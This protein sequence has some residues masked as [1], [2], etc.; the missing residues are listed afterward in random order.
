MT[1]IFAHRGYSAKYP[2]NTMQ[3]FIEAEK[4]GADAL[5]IDVQLTKDGEV[6]IIH[7]EKVDRVTNG[8]GYVKE[9][10]YKEMRKLD[11]GFHKK[12]TAKKEP[13]P[14]LEELLEWMTT[15]RLICNIELKNN[16]IPYE[17]ME[18]KVIE[19]VRKYNLSNRIIISSFNHYSIVYSYR[20]APEIEI[21]PLYSESLFM[22]WV[23]AKSIRAKGIHPKLITATDEV[24]LSSIE[25]GIQV[26]P[27]T[28]N[29]E[30]DMK[31]LFLIGC[32]AL[33]TD[34]P[35]KA[36]KIRQQIQTAT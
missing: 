2:E 30:D 16:L 19:L 9:L 23:Y 21:A 17:G 14:S 24:I 11:A 34:E 5:E 8:Q 15:N 25:N 20:L 33:I 22:P 13:I 29:K 28:V 36:L 26:R 7:D 1:M 4:A 6:V 35:K 18:E 10:T 3:A 31:R 12:T 32:S 27:Y